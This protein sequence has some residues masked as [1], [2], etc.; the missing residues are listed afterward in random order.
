MSV[1]RARCWRS[2]IGRNRVFERGDCGCSF[3]YSELEI[4]RRIHTDLHVIEVASME[5][6]AEARVLYAE[7]RVPRGTNV[8]L[9]S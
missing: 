6:F 8:Q 1:G 5:H 9:V 3:G 2:W 7:G 4:R